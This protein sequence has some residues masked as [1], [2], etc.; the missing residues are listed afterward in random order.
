[1][2]SNRPK[3]MKGAVGMPMEMLVG[4]LI[5]VIILLAILWMLGMVPG[6]IDA[7]KYRGAMNACCVSYMLAGGCDQAVSGFECTVGP[8]I[9]QPGQ[10]GGV[11]TLEWLSGQ[12]GIPITNCCK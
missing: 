7:E 8:D 10:K 5:V 6:P 9:K 4:I 12:S 1:M 3:R 2:E 11:A